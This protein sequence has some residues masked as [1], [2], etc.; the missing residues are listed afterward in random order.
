MAW[1][2]LYNGYY[3]GCWL[4]LVVLSISLRIGWVRASPARCGVFFIEALAP[5]ADQ[6]AV[7]VLE[8]EASEELVAHA[9]V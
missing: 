4:L 5:G 1:S 2:G 6:G 8:H 7:Q 3:E 9:V